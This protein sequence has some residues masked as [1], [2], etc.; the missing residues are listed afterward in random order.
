MAAVLNKTELSQNSELGVG[1]VVPL[2]ATC[3]VS[4]GLRGLSNVRT[5]P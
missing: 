2:R 5:K 1:T 4:V 3:V